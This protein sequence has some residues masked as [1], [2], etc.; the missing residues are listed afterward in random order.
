MLTAQRHFLD[1]RLWTSL[2]EARTH[3][4]LGYGEMQILFAPQSDNYCNRPTYIFLHG[5]EGGI[6]STVDLAA[7]IY[8][9]ERAN[10]CL[11]NY[12]GEQGNK[13]KI[14]QAAAVAALKKAIDYLVKDKHLLPQSINVLGSS[15]GAD[16]AVLALGEKGAEGVGSGIGHLHL[17]SA[18]VLKTCIP[19]VAKKERALRVMDRALKLFGQGDLFKFLAMQD[20]LQLAES[21][22]A[23]KATVHHGSKDEII[24]KEMAEAYLKALSHAPVRG[25]TELHIYPEGMHGDPNYW[26]AGM[27]S[28]R[29]AAPVKAEVTKIKRS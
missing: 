22:I 9:N 11:I 17:L 24:P 12:P 16:T 7:H 5:R 18:P 10:I 29:G 13:G 21:V 28:P 4:V 1:K 20:A 14:S 6:G 15:M 3:K 19:A 23:H 25:G 8:Q 27:T 2:A 26:R